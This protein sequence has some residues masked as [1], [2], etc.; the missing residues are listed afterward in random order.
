MKRASSFLAADP[1]AL[2]LAFGLIVLSALVIGGAAEL[3]PLLLYVFFLY[4]CAGVP[5]RR[6]VKHIK[7]V[8]PFIVLILVVNAL[9]V[10]GDP[11]FAR[12]PLLSRDGA[13]QGVHYGVRF[14]VLYLSVALFLIMASPEAIAGGVAAMFRPVSGTFAR[15]AALH[16]F[17][18][19]GYLPLFA[20]EIERIRVAQ[21]FRGGGLDG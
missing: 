17:L 4:R 8:T 3:V 10:R 1:R 7:T 6:V 19:I 21:R 15:R 13:V 18:A 16:S 2:M 9:L 14:L 11:L 12:V 5:A 20:G